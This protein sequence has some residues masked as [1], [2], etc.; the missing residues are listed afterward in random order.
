MKDKYIVRRV[1]MECGISSI[2]I[3]GTNFSIGLKPDK[4]LNVIHNYKV[5]DDGTDTVQLRYEDG[6]VDIWTYMP[7]KRYIEEIVRG[8]IENEEV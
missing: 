6:C 7:R 5:I 3:V 1:L 8:E 4:F 2:G